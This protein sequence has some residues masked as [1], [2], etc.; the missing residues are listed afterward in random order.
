M[1]LTLLSYLASAALLAAASTA[2]AA[3]ITAG[4]QAGS[5]VNAVQPLSTGVDEFSSRHGG[6]GGG[7]GWGGHGGGGRT[8]FGG[9]GGFRHVGGHGFRR[10]GFVGHRHGFVRPGFRHRHF[11]G[12]RFFGPRFYPYY[13]SYPSCYRYWWRGLLI[14]R[15]YPYAYYPHRW[16]RRLAMVW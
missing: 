5:N 12:R 7:R 16:H 3:P 11:V 1:R 6:G 15:C 4:E 2:N 8:H 13:A 14:R 10:A 9:G